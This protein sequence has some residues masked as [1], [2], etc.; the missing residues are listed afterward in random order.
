MELFALGLR[1]VLDA[2]ALT[3]EEQWASGDLS[4]LRALGTWQRSALWEL[5]RRSLLPSL[6][7]SAIHSSLGTL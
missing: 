3:D 6:R 1:C 7:E 5:A 4:K 2:Q